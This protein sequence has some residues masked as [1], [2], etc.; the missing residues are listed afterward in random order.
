LSARLLRATALV[1]GSAL[2]AAC[3]LAE[4]IT[5]EADDLLVVEAVLRPDLNV[6]RLLLHSSLTADV[7][8]AEQGARVVVRSA[9]GREIV[10]VETR[11]N[12]L[13]LD[14]APVGRVA[15]YLSPA[16]E[17]AWVRP[18]EEYQLRIETRD[19][20]L[21]YART[22]VPGDF[23]LRVPATELRGL[24]HL[25]PDTPLPL[26][27]SRSVGTWAYISELEISGLR[28]ALVGRVPGEIPDRISLTGL[29][30]SEADTSMVLPRD[31]GI[32]QRTQFDQPLLVALRDGLPLGTA[33]NLVLAAVDRN[34]VNAVRGG[35]FNPSGRVR[36]PSVGG[37]ATG[38][39]G[40][41]I[42][43]TLQI[44]VRQPAA[45]RSCL[46]N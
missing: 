45:G 2:L 44:E 41:M 35:S 22:Q 28:A 3:T 18:G 5:P 11:Q 21:A 32:F 10:F 17:G 25:P 12:D 37:D 39:F 31:F 46:A 9:A 8:G 4:V 20:R 19:G 14:S 13:C 43:R 15:C 26:V 29:A 38:M 42:I 34:Y 36:I 6:Q 23:R 27:W 16:R 40:S 33:A 24:C 1:L 30:I 7:A